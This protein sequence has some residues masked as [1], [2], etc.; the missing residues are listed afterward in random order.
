MG[1]GPEK[2]F[3]VFYW[4]SPSKYPG[5][6]GKRVAIVAA[7]DKSEASYKFQVEYK[8]EFHTIDHIEEA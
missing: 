6:I 2:A 7:T 3:K 8:G 1:Y 5:V 4:P